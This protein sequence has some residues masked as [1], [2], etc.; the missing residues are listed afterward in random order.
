MHDIGTSIDLDGREL[1]Q[2]IEEAS[3]SLRIFMRSSRFCW[4]PFTDHSTE[5]RDSLGHRCRGRMCEGETVSHSQHIGALLPHC[6]NSHV[7][8]EQS[9]IR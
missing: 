4:S 6:A 9:A 8:V 1:H 7:R 3:R 5:T 2:G